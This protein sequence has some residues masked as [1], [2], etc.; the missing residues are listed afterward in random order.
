MT[1]NQNENTLPLTLVM[2]ATGKTGRR[3]AERLES[4]GVPVRRGS[5]TG[6]PAFSW[7]NRSTWSAALEGV[8]AVYV[9]YPTDIAAPGALEDIRAFTEVA[10]QSTVQRL[11]LLSGRGEEAAQ[12]SER[13][14]AQSG[15]EWTVIQ[16]AWFHQNFDEGP[17]LDLV[18]SGAITLPVT[19]VLEPF[20][21]ADDVADVAVAALTEEGHDGETYELTGPRLMTFADAAAELAKATGREIHFVPITREEFLAG[22]EQ[23]GMPADYAGMLGYLFEF[24][25]DG[26]NAHLADGVQRALGREPRD[27]AVY[28]RDAAESGAWKVT[29]SDIVRCLIDKVLNEGEFELLHEL[30]HPNY[31]YRSPREELRGPEQLEAMLRGYRSAFPDMQVAID[32]VVE[33]GSKVSLSF[34]LTGT[35]LGELSG[36]PATGKRVQLKGMILSR[37]EG[38]QIVEEWELLDQFALFAQLGLVSLSA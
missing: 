3:V 5:R 8:G 38:G 23:A 6:S 4:K 26:R 37:V 21:D 27:F 15:L 33:Q 9:V 18:M 14:I 35:H 17:F 30:V 1:R 19:D 10:K 29:N 22:L 16:A 2:A 11:V 7:E 36:V 31:V 20:V 34:T 12:A 13:V 24:V 25:L 32:D 28:A